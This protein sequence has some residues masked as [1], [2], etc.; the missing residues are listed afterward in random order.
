MKDGCSLCGG[1]VRNG[2]C[3]EC[4]MD[5]RKSDKM[6]R[7]ALNQ[8]ECK[9]ESL[10]HV[11]NDKNKAEQY[12]AP[13]MNKTR[14]TKS[15]YTQKK[16]QSQN[17]AQKSSASCQKKSFQP[18]GSYSSYKYTS[19]S[20]NTGKGKNRTLLA[21]VIAGIIMIIGIV[22][23]SIASYSEFASMTPEYLG[24]DYEIY[25]VPEEEWNPA[26]N[27]NPEGD[28]WKQ[29]LEPGTYVAGVDLPEGKYEV[30]GNGGSSFQVTD[31]RNAAYMTESFTMNDDDIAEIYEVS[32]YDVVIYEGA[33]I[34]VDGMRPV[35]FKTENGQVQD[36]KAKLENPLKETFEI[37]GQAIA[38]VDFPAGTYDITA[39]GEEYG[40]LK[41]EIPQQDE[42]AYP[43]SFS[44]LM[45]GAPSAEYP[46][47][48][49]VYKNVVLPDGAIIDTDEFTV[50]LVPS[51]EITTEDYS[52]FYDNMY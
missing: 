7:H 35:V 17:H 5:N 6:Y 42:S 32:V 8:G 43:L 19:Y 1:K 25:P 21:V 51:Q 20:G 13:V 50:N 9:Q 18:S 30:T 12:R 39:V 33:L 15:A 10:T 48:C 11:H 34:Y 4:G 36:M 23:T 22:A 16:P 2:I 46:E 47:Y 41:Y 31:A 29:A 40:V 45:D 28:T 24:E 52:N 14:E 37:T 44:V 27:L 26:K 38:G 49:K 3:T